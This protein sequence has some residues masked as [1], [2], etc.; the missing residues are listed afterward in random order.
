M[1]RIAS[2]LAPVAVVVSAAACTACSGAAQKTYS[3]AGFAAAARSEAAPIVGE[4]TV[5]LLR[6]RSIDAMAV[7]R[8]FL[9]WAALGARDPDPLLMQR[10]LETGKVEQ[11]RAEMLPQ[12]GLAVSPTWAV[13]GSSGAP[14]ELVALRHEG[15]DRTVLSEALIAPIDSRGTLVA[16]AEG[17]ETEQRVLVREMES[18]REWLAARMPRCIGGR[19]YRIDKVTLAD[20]GVVFSR[21][22][23]GPHPSLIVRRGFDDA[24]PA[25]ISVPNDPQPD[26]ILSSAGAFYYQFGRGW[27]RWDFGQARPRPAGVRDQ[28]GEPF[29]IAFDRG[30][31]L[32]VHHVRCTSTL[33]VRDGGRIS[34]RIAP[35]RS[36][37]YS[38]TEFGPLCRELSSLFWAGQKLLVA[39]S[40]VPKLSLDSHTSVGLVGV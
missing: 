7:S 34:R 27:M 32:L 31:L 16:W 17:D 22:A 26:L 20:R 11:L 15:S 37:R 9:V 36:T 18:G 38:P 24:R 6:D 39:W 29:P 14:A 3:S 13:F 30:R 35:P 4:G 21:G 5:I 19:C 12:L 8:R 25:T 40:V 33:L 23:V 28:G 1:K 10:D 2:V